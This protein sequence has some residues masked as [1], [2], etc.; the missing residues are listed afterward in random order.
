MQLQPSVIIWTVICFLLFMLVIDRLLFRPLLRHMDGR[1]E[2][3]AR[4]EERKNAMARELEE[5]RLTR[6]LEAEAARAEAES[7]AKAELESAKAQC[8]AE[9]AAYREELEK[10]SEAAKEQAA[11]ADARDR[12]LVKTALDGLA[13][14]YA[15]KLIASK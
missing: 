12:E 10:R 8:E 7:R 4:A 1:R 6:R 13:A 3:I 9:L 14:E 5:Q 2:R 11:A 15:D